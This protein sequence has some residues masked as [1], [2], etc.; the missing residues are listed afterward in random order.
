M[1]SERT[2]YLLTKDLDLKSSDSFWNY[3]AEYIYPSSLALVPII[4]MSTMTNYKEVQ[5]KYTHPSTVAANHSS[6]HDL[7]LVA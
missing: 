1:L 3:T 6:A 2:E 5:K 7:F 4:W